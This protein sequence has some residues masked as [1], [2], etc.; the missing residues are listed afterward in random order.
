M[1][2]SDYGPGLYKW[3]QDWYRAPPGDKAKNLFSLNNRR[4][5]SLANSISIKFIEPS[6]NDERP[7]NDLLLN[8]TDHLDKVNNLYE[9]LMGSF[10][11]EIRS[12]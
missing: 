9:I 12:R 11:N 8:E 3:M 5:S 6:K 10:G 2:A 1:I 4:L 7:R